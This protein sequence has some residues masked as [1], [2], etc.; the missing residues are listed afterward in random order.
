MAGK[1]RG[2]ELPHRIP[3]VAWTE[4]LS[5]VA[6]A[7]P[8]PSPELRQRMQAAVQAE[9][10]E[11]AAREQKRAA[12]DR[13]TEP[14]QQVPPSTSAAGGETGP[15]ASSLASGT[16]GERADAAAEPAPRPEHITG[17]VPEDEGTGSPG[18]A[19]R[20]RPAVRLEPVSRART[21][22]APEPAVRPRPGRPRR[23]AGGRL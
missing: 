7:A 10:A 19:A 11:A 1:E 3:G 18:S 8:V 20:P 4:P 5:P 6:P 9:R 14:S 15:V 17:P 21:A 23:R 13:T 12:G 22:A 16:N 2:T